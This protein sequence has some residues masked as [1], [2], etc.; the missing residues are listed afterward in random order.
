MP[1]AYAHSGAQMPVGVWANRCRA[2][3]RPSRSANSR[4][5]GF[6]SGWNGCA[7]GPPSSSMVPASISSRSS[8]L[9]P[10]RHS[11]VKSSSACVGFGDARE[12]R[13][14]RNGS[15]AAGASPRMRAQP[16]VGQPV[17]HAVEAVR[18]VELCGDHRRHAQGDQVTAVLGGQRAQHPHQRQ[19]GRRPRLVEPFLA[20]RPAAVVGQPRQVGVQDE[21][22]EPGHRPAGGRVTGAPRSRPGPGC[23]RCRASAASSQVE[24]VGA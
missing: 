7:S 21:G 1:G 18:V 9:P 3:A 11:V 24:I 15:D 14:A 23:R 20:D 19:V 4:S 2:S 10:C 12:C 13:T 16:P 17:M 5:R 8:G 6:S 22:E